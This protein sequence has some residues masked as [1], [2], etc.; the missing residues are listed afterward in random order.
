MEN[1]A[2]T[3]NKTGLFTKIDVPLKQARAVVRLMAYAANEGSI[4]HSDEMMW[5]QQVV[6]GLIDSAL[7]AAEQLAATEE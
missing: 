5:A 2:Q 4:D 6:S 1:T 7:I 3:P